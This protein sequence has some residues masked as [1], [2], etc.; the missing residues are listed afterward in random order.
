MK[1]VVF[2]DVDG[3]LL[4][5]GHTKPLESTKKALAQLQKQGIGVVLCTGRHPTEIIALGLL[6]VP[7]DGFVLLNVQHC[8]DRNM[9]II[10]SY[11]I[12]GRDQ[13]EIIDLF[14][15]KE[16]PVVIAEEDRLYL[17]FINERV[18]QA[19]A[20]VASG[21]HP[22]GVYNGADILMSTIYTDKK[23]EF[24]MLRTGRWH[25]WAVDVYPPTGGKANGIKEYIKRFGIDDKDTIVFW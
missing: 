9:K 3:T 8:L 2:L 21:V 12:E 23:V 7:Y 22:T 19:Q 10:F 18:I 16:M 4:P 15:K 24:S 6:D 5:E 1:K 25:Q 17:S 20:D 11:P 14:Q 13:E